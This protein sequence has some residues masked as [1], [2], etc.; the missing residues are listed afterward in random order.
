MKVVVDTNVWISGL[1]WK[2]APS[3]LLRLA[4]HG[5]IDLWASESIVAEFERVLA[6][7]RMQR[8]LQ[9]LQLS[10]SAVVS[11]ALQ[12]MQIAIVDVSLP[13]EGVS[14]DPDD[15]MFLS[16]ALSV[17]AAYLVSGD[18]HL[19]DLGVWRGI[20]IVTVNDFLAQHFPETR[21]Q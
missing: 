19:L 6:Y 13:E 17:G 1:L 21:S 20:H 14:A 16:C 9:K 7:Q 8:Q 11:F 15:D 3:R 18:R 2:G 4:E 5:H 12:L 10:Q